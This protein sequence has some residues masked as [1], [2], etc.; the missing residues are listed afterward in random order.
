MEKVYLGNHSLIKNLK[1]MKA[2]RIKTMGFYLLVLGAVNQSFAQGNTW[3][4]FGNN[5][6]TSESFIGSTTNNADL[7]F[8]TNALERLRITSTGEFIFGKSIFLSGNATLDSLF[9]N[10]I[11]TNTLFSNNVRVSG[12]IKLDGK[13][14]NSILSTNDEDST[15]SIN[16]DIAATGDISASG[17]LKS[18]NTIIIDGTQVG[19][20]TSNDIL[21]TTGILS[22]RRGAN[23]AGKMRLGVGEKIP[24]K[25]IHLT[26]S[27]NAFDLPVGL[28]HSGIR[29]EDNLF[30][31]VGVGIF[32]TR[33]IV[34]STIW[35]IEPIARTISDTAVLRISSPGSSIA[36][37]DFCAFIRAKDVVVETDWCDF[38]FEENYKRMTYEERAKFF[39]KNKRLPWIASAKQIAANGLS[40]GQTM[41]GFAWNIEEISLNQIDL[42]KMILEV[43]EEVK[44]VKKENEVLKEE[45]QEL[46][47]E[48]DNL[49]QT[50]QKKFHWY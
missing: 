34:A 33:Q 44:Q 47:I 22:F 4:L 49:K 11:S 42:Y 30:D 45:N 1:K 7:I 2:R 43:K 15:V 10:F 21:S 25:G 28:T 19:A 5:N 50:Q 8:K 17:I 26:T 27:H 16:G 31:L 14:L 40:I 36:R 48:N 6:V 29:L 46:K 3:K 39:L 41:K 38:V 37:V 13:L 24:Q 12:D 20:D 23:T 18:G 9:A 32:K 35:D